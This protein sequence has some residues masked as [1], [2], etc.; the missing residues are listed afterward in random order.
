M[1]K[2]QEF[3]Y[4]KLT[5][6]PV[7]RSLVGE[8]I[9]YNFQEIATSFPCITFFEVSATPRPT[10]DVFDVMYEI[11][12]WDKPESQ[13]VETLFRRVYTLFDD[14]SST[15]SGIIR[16]RIVQVREA[17]EGDI[18]RKSVDVRMLVKEV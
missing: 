13:S 3:I 9:S 16:S 1:T 4:R 12:I 8:N 2:G 10:R 7:I 14:V 15:S 5:G 18:L 11:D 17:P 6:D